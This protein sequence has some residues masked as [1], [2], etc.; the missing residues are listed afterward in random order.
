MSFSAFPGLFGVAA[1]IVLGVLLGAA[2]CPQ[3]W[4]AS[5]APTASAH[6]ADPDAAPTGDHAGHQPAEMRDRDDPA[7]SDRSP[8]PHHAATSHDGTSCIGLIAAATGAAII[9]EPVAAHALLDEACASQRVDRPETP[10]PR[11]LLAS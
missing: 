7:P 1:V 4:V 10:I 6:S 11:L 9:T 5:A 8:G 3:C 2:A